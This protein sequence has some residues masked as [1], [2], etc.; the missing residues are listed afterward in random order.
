[1]KKIMADYAGCGQCGI[2]ASHGG[3]WRGR[4]RHTERQKVHDEIN[5][6]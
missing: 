2:G 4:E 3:G 5:L 1:M 6:L